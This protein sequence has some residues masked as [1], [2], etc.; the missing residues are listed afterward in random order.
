MNRVASSFDCY[1][2]R[3]NR[4]DALVEDKIAYLHENL[5]VVCTD[6]LRLTLEGDTS[7]RRPRQL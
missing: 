2:A 1:A 4:A 3:A 7:D 6:N 5:Q